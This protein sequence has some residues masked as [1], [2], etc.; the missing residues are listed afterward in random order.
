MP[1]FPFPTK[2]LDVGSRSGQQPPRTSRDMNNVRPYYDGRDCGGQRPGNDKM[3]SDRIGDNANYPVVK[4]LSV[5]IV[6]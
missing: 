1:T 5:T 3:F 2:G 6:D 4:I